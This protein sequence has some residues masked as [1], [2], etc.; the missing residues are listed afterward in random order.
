MLLH[1][2]IEYT[3]LGKTEVVDMGSSAEYLSKSLLR[4]SWSGRTHV[5]YFPSEQKADYGVK[6]EFNCSELCFCNFY[7]LDMH[8]YDL[9]ISHCPSA[10][11]FAS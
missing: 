2:E 1:D 7:D 11:G 8:L 3:S 9:I 4:P 6:V 10:F 5:S